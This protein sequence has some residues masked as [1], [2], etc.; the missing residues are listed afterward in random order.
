M[1]KAFEKNGFR[2]EGVFRQGMFLSGRYAD[3]FCYSLL[4]KDWNE[5][6]ATAK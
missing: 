1:Q 3:I 2:K 4:A 6:K 5:R